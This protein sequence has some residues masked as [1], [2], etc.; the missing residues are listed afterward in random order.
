MIEEWKGGIPNVPYAI[1]GEN[2]PKV[3]MNGIYCNIKLCLKKM[4]L[5]LFFV[6][7]GL[8]VTVQMSEKVTPI[9]NVIGRI[10]GGEVRKRICLVKFEIIFKQHC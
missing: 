5:K 2:G 7:V 6:F 1:G 4:I 3:S 9:W 10:D 8:L